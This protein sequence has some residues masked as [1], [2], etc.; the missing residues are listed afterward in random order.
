MRSTHVSLGGRRWGGVFCDSCGQVEGICRQAAD[1]GYL[2]QEFHLR[3][4]HVSILW[5]EIISRD[6]LR[7]SGVLQKMTHP[8]TAGSWGHWQLVF[9]SIFISQSPKSAFL[10]PYNGFG[11]LLVIHLNL[12]PVLQIC[13]HLCMIHH[14]VPCFSFINCIMKTD[15]AEGIRRKGKIDQYLFIFL[16]N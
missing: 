6:Y 8:G 16:G 9:C 5:L 10:S 4:L 2:R 1:K 11:K 3:I 13:D 14:S 7:L 15:E 12:F